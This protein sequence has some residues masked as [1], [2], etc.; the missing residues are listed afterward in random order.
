MKL[1]KTSLLIASLIS[2]PLVLANNNVDF[3]DSKQHY[4]GFDIGYGSNDFDIGLQYAKSLNNDWS[5]LSSYS[6]DDNF[7]NHELGFD[8]QRSDGL[9]LVFEY[10]HDTNFQSDNLRANDYSFSLYKANTVNEQFSV[11][12]Q[13]TLGNLK[14]Q[15]MSSS[16]YYT[17]A[18]LDMT[19]N[20][21]PSM[22]VGFTPEYTYSLGKVKE[23]NDNQSTLRDWDYTAELGY[24]LN[25]TSAFVYSYQYDD[26]NN[27]SLF[28]FKHSF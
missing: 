2:S 13:V 8:F 5:L 15:Q 11:V 17:S 20:L 23:K 9:G 18:S 12:P 22:W 25:S 24:Q 4:S 27:L 19:Y 3:S 14:H 28:S 1:T 10:E 6:S 21:N 26:G 7:D 16:V